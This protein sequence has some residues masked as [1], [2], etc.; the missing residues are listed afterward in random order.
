MH[1]S[2]MSSFNRPMG[3]NMNMFSPG[4]SHM[5]YP[6]QE[7]GKGKGKARD[8]AF[9]AAFAEFST[10]AATVSSAKIEEIPQNLSELE[11][12]FKNTTISDSDSKLDERAATIDDFKTYAI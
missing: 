3:M 11:N 9:E 7:Q 8:D 1:G 10:E 5:S 4:F 6:T 12:R 2:Y